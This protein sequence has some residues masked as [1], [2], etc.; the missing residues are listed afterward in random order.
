[1]SN[2]IK[3]GFGLADITIGGQDMGLQ[4]DAATFTAEP[5]Y[6][7]VE[8]YELGLYDLYL[9]SWAVSLKVVFQEESFDKLKMALPALDEIKNG[10]TTIGLTDGKI[11]QRMRDKAVEI[12]VHPKDAG[13]D[14]DYDLTI[15]KAF[16][17]GAFERVYGKD[18]VKYEV[19]FK[20]LPLTG[21]SSK[22]G[23]YFRI[24]QE[25]TVEEE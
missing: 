21:D 22:G 8:T 19:E 14:T 4:G 11:H 10:A 5:Q 25:G 6:L 18:V 1:M 12:K 16:P 24:G 3:V 23:N 17:T 2:E 15:F 9:D 20:A 7:D 13:A